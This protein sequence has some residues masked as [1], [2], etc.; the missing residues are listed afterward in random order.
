VR[1]F[2]PFANRA[3]RWLE[4]IGDFARINRRMHNKSITADSQA[5][6]VGGRNIGDEYFAATAAV[7]FGDFDVIAIGPVVREVSAEFDRYWNSASAWPIA[8][9][10]TGPSADLA[11]LRAQVAASIQALIGTPYAKALQSADLARRFAEKH[12][13]LYWGTAS[14]IADDPEKVRLPAA[15]SSTHAAPKLKAALGGAQKE[16]LLVSPYFVPGEQGVRWLGETVARGVRVRV[17]TNSYLSNDVT[18]VHAGYAAHREELLRA[19]VELMELKPTATAQLAH[20]GKMRTRGSSGSAL[21][22]KTY[23]ADARTLFVG[24]FNLDPRSSRLNT[25]MGIVIQSP[26]LCAALR[27]R[28]LPRLAEI[29]Y[30]VELD[31]SSS[32]LAWVT[33]EDGRGIRH[34]SEPG[35]G[36]LQKLMLGLLRLLPIEEQL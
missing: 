6:I 20:E 2:N 24:S 25:E 19:G 4:M 12:L 22:A 18:A 33:Q 28:L 31:K 11:A 9:L 16:L 27:E 15:D 26:E 35:V 8:A 30:R 14:V 7:E 23:M 21:H 5:S 34:D 10:A 32:A 36:P 1:L 29:A 17:L 13:P 3:V